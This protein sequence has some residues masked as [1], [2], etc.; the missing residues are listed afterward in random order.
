MN[1]QQLQLALAQRALFELGILLV[2]VIGFFWAMYAVT[3]AAITRL[4][5]VRR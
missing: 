5:G 2:I 3:K 1:L 4:Q